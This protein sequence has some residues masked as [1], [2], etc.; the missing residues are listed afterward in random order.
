MNETF[1]LFASISIFIKHTCFTTVPWYCDPPV[2][3]PR[4]AVEVDVDLW[5]QETVCLS[6]RH[7][8][9]HL[10]GGSHGLFSPTLSPGLGVK[11]KTGS[12]L[13]S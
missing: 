11:N 10:A 2:G 6:L 9:H 8:A 3:R 13:T 7:T 5:S 1:I 4:A 12:E